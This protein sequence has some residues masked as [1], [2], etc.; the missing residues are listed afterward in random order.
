MSIFDEPVPNWPFALKSNLV[1]KVKIESLLCVTTSYTKVTK[2]KN[3]IH[4]K[5][6]KQSD[7]F[8]QFFMNGGWSESLIYLTSDCL[9]IFLHD[10]QNLHWSLNGMF[11]S[12]YIFITKR[13]FLR[14]RKCS[15]PLCDDIQ[16]KP[17]RAFICSNQIPSYRIHLKC[18]VYFSL[19]WVNDV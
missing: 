7:L 9:A 18:Y 11:N 15:S 5:N 10:K 4:C 2:I 6:G 19:K 13:V 16:T 12:R 1:T 17:T 3:E 14:C 8:C